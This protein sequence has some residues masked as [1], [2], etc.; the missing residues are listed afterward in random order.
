MRR[1]VSFAPF[2]Q[3]SVTASPLQAVKSARIMA[4]NVLDT[5][6]ARRCLVVDD[7]PRLRQALVRLMQGDGRVICVDTVL[8]PMGDASS[9]TA[10]LLD[11]HMMVLIPGKERT[12]AQ[13]QALYQ[14]AGFRIR[15]IT[16]IQD[17]F[18]TSIIEGVK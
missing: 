6:L 18:G 8:P 10:K 12:E 3:D 9:A 14:A 1:R 5:A 13:W 16:P 2:N 11:L 4:D 17:N 15:S 7:E